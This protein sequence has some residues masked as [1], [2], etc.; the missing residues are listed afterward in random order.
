[1]I[2][3][4]KMRRKQNESVSVSHVKEGRRHFSFV[5]E[6]VGAWM[7]I[8]LGIWMMGASM[9]A[10]SAE[11]LQL[12]A[13]AA[14]LMDAESGRVLYGK[15]EDLPLAN[16]ST[17]KIMTCIVV[18]ENCDLGET[19]SISAYAASMP[20]VKLGVSC[21]EQYEVQSLLYSLMLESHNDSAVALAEHVGKQWVPELREKDEKDFTKEESEWAVKAFAAR[22][23]QKAESLGCVDTYFITPNG[24]DATETKDSV[25]YEHHTTARD[26]AAML[27][28]CILES[29]KRDVFLQ[30]TREPQYSFTGNGRS[31]Y[32]SNH[33]SFLGMM[34]GA[35]SGKTGF[36]GKAGYCYVG[37][38]K[39]DGR[40]Y[41]VALLACGWPN[42]KTYKWSDTRKLMEYGIQKYRR[43]NLLDDGILF[44]EKQLPVLPVLEGQGRHLGE[45]ALAVLEIAGRR[46]IGET[47]NMENQE[48]ENIKSGEKGI[49][50]KDDEKVQVHVA[51]LRELNAPVKA[52][53]KVGEIRYE[54]DGQIYLTEDVFVRDT[55]E[56]IDFRWC[57]LQVLKIFQ[58][59]GGEE[60]WQK[61]S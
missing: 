25:T 12:Y 47:A 14:V 60:L 54:V 34:D 59:C 5:F 57:L 44:P 53:Q 24:L 56:K 46:Q 41:V 6:C 31:Y 11:E 39:R 51:I 2:G 49:L 23:N 15:S 1:M 7:G 61:S 37:A 35:L 52:G 20:K 27:S 28:Y 16:A 33:N 55:I 22:M 19:L 9:A 30:I 43:V 29:P 4:Q 10:A 3:F 26:L 58:E 13:T 36:T 8:F 18:L 42:N 21:G 40:Y 17:T 50:L 32:C 38:L 48:N 45:D